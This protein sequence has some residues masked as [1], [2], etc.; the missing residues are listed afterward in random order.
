M[1]EITLDKTLDVKP[2][3][4]SIELSIKRYAAP[5]AKGMF[6]DN[7]WVFDGKE[8]IDNSIFA[9]TISGKKYLSAAAQYTSNIDPLPDCDS[10]CDWM[11]NSHMVC[12]LF[13][14]GAGTLSL[15]EVIPLNIVRDR[16][17]LKGKPR[18]QSIKAMAVAGAA[19]DVLLITLGYS[20]SAE[21]A[22]ARYEPP[23]FVTTIALHF[24]STPG[25]LRVE[26]RDDCLGNPNNYKTIAAARKRLRECEATIPR[27]Q[28]AGA[29]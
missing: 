14:F 4:P 26:Q 21:P 29:R 23:E 18:C 13:L 11:V 19:R 5:R 15:A 20:D 22:E 6:S 12:H 17:L 16:R 9:W 10:N 3:I 2:V 27:S 1:A 24:D 8:D 7:I 28:E 25:V